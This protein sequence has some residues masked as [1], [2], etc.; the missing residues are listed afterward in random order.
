MRAFLSLI[1]A[2]VLVTAGVF[3]PLFYL[4]LEVSKNFSDALQVA[5]SPWI[6]N[7]ALFTLWQAG[8][9]SVL[10]VVLAV[11]LA[12]ILAHR[13][14]PGRRAL[15]ALSALP[16]ALPSVLVAFAFVL[17]YGRSGIFRA[18]TGVEF[19]FLYNPFAVVAAH[20]FFNLPFALRQ[21]LHSLE[22]IPCEQLR[23][24]ELLGLGVFK[25][26]RVLV[27]PHVRATVGSLWL[28]ITI[29]C[30][31]SFAIVL[32][33]GG[34]PE[35]TTLEV[36]IYQ[37]LRFE[38][39]PAG[40]S[41]LAFAQLLLLLPAVA[42]YRRI[43][44]QQPPLSSGARGGRFVPRAQKPS[45]G[46]R[47]LGAMSIF[48]YVVFLLLPLVG[49]AFDAFRDA[50]RAMA[51]L[52]SVATLKSVLNSLAL[53]LPASLLCVFASWGFARFVATQ[54]LQWPRFVAVSSHSVWFLMGISPT[55]LTL[56]WIVFLSAHDFDPYNEPYFPVLLV[57]TLLALPLC[58]RILLPHAERVHGALGWSARSIGLRGFSLMRS[59]EWPEMRRPLVSAA[60]IAFS[61]SF[62]DV[63]AVLMFGGG[64]FTTLPMH[65]F[66]L[67]GAY[68]F[69]AAALASVLL[70]C[71]CAGFFYLSESRL[72]Q[73]E[74]KS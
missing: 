5:T 44:G 13:D 21:I 39:N 53:A 26:W 30:L 29:L 49:L 36:A 43:A 17:A 7:A 6:Q 38:A 63:S 54:K 14:W 56:A 47:V 23:A 27:W 11:P 10:S 34:G 16:F 32:I 3:L 55:V 60:L 50:E 2:F 52:A 57:H 19:D 8:I 58:I 25:R 28:L 67:M 24:A 4:L 73:E 42:L 40:A 46:L 59:V 72:I 18:I 65:I 15:L 9:S 41:A 61:F 70:A 69:A 71:I 1:P 31:S 35:A 62:G 51:T 45:P 33:L 22:T 37:L 68:R 12:L 20:V 64:T 74:K 66:E 48:T